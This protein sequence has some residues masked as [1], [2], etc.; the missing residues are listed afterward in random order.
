MKKITILFMFI[1]FSFMGC[2]NHFKLPNKI[3]SEAS[4][5]N[6]TY[7]SDNLNVGIFNFDLSG[8]DSLSIFAVDFTDIY[9]NGLINSIC[10]DFSITDNDY[11]NSRYYI[12]VYN[13]TL[14]YKKAQSSFRIS[15]KTQNLSLSSES[16]DS[17]DLYSVTLYKATNSTEEFTPEVAGFFFKI[18]DYNAR[19]S[20]SVVIDN[21]SWDNMLYIPRTF[22]SIK[23]TIESE[24]DITEAYLKV[25]NSLSK[26]TIFED[27]FPNTE[28]SDGKLIVT[29]YLT[30]LSPGT[31]YTWYLYISGS[32][33]VVDYEK[34][35]VKTYTDETFRN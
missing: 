20:L 11:Q 12:D 3:V 33:G 13:V 19:S 1:T 17:G 16:V 6:L 21:M 9:Y 23:Y 28:P 15:D 22:M 2:A 10:F 25:V 35:L 24:H 4:E 5:D 30:E 32:D 31:S 29:K 8:K 18:N 26:E 7:F 14:D 27:V 34:I